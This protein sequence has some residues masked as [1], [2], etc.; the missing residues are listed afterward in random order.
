MVGSGSG[1]YCL[2]FYTVLSFS[3]GFMAVGVWET[4][5]GLGLSTLR[6]LIL[7]EASYSK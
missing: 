4:V 7:V 6:T 3:V 5:L 2:G 1:F